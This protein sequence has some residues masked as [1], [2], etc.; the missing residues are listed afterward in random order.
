M[1]SESC[2]SCRPHQAQIDITVSEVVSLRMFPC[3][4]VV[5]RSGRMDLGA[6]S[7]TFQCRRKSSPRPPR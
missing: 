3:A 6:C 7:K 5:P 1:T 2:L 4:V